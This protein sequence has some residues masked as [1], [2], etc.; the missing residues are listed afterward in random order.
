MTLAWEQV[1][2]V[3]KSLNLDPHSAECSK[4]GAPLNSK[5]LTLSLGMSGM[6]KTL[7]ELS[8]QPSVP[9]AFHSIEFED[10]SGLRG[11]LFGYVFRCM[12]AFKLE[13]DE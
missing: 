9:K 6:E 2:Q 13:A 7:R 5:L 4:K 12:T 1:I 11:Y 3:I 10:Y 8:P